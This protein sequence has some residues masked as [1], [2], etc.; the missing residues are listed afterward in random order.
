MSGVAPKREVTIAEWLAM[1][2]DRRLELI[3]GELVKKA[4][5]TFEHGLAQAGTV[6]AVRGAR[7]W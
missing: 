6:A 5:P 7:D 3:D 2:E 1:P 4:A